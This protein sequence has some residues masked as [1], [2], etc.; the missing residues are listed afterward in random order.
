MVREWRHLGQG[1][2]ASP[3]DPRNFPRSFGARQSLHLDGTTTPG[4]CKTLGTRNTETRCRTKVTHLGGN[5]CG[6]ARENNPPYDLDKRIL[7]GVHDLDRT[8]A[9]AVTVRRRHFQGHI[10]LIDSLLR[11]HRR[12][13]RKEGHVGHE[14][15]S[16][17]RGRAN[18][19]GRQRAPC[20]KAANTLDT[21][22][23]SSQP[24]G[25]L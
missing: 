6:Q 15:P 19:G 4:L 8:R 22:D 2:H 18:R 20:C 5:I 13:V 24:Q 16:D 25:H 11:Q 7:D 14:D 3:F 9:G 12:Q 23:A 1:K 10:D 21:P 17:H